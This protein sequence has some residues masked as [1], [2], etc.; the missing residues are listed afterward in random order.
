[1]MASFLF[2]LTWDLPLKNICEEGRPYLERYFLFAVNGWVFYI[3]RFVGSD[4]DR[5]LH[6]HPWRIAFSIILS[7]WYWEETSYGTHKVKWFN[8]LVGDSKHR[9]VLPFDHKKLA[10]FDAAEMKY[11]A[12][13]CWTLFFHKDVNAKKW[14]FSRDAEQFGFGAGSEV[15]IPFVSERKEGDAPWWT[16]AKTR[17][18]LQAEG[19]CA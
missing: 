8:W 9:V 12:I 16:T 17:R 7:G 2:W 1:M 5:G 18:Q 4:P 3:H 10:F 15:F 19:A 11:C 6:C 14:G 13:P